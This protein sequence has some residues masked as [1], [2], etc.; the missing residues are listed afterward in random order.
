MRVRPKNGEV[1]VASYTADPVCAG[2]NETAAPR[3]GRAP[4]ASFPM[5]SDSLHLPPGIW[6]SFVRTQSEN[7]GHSSRIV[8]M[9]TSPDGCLG[10]SLHC[11]T[12]ND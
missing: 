11:S 1:S 10:P 6:L 7:S 9:P 5:F 4:C 12:A 3:E 2:R 8:V